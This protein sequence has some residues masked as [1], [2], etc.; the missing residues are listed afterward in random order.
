[1]CAA[2]CFVLHY[3]L[4]PTRTLLF[5][6]S[7][8]EMKMRLCKKMFTAELADC[9][10]TCIS[11]HQDHMGKERIPAIAQTARMP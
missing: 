3:N 5:C 10:L 4:C 2:S 6:S 9:K 8:Y 1:M 11:E 7:M